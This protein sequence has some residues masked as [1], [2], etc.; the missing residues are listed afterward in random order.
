M[1]KGRCIHSMTGVENS[2]VT[3]GA[4]YTAM[5]WTIPPTPGILAPLLF[6]R[7]L[8]RLESDCATKARS[9]VKR[10][11]PTAHN[12]ARSHPSRHQNV[13]A[14]AMRAKIKAGGH[15]APCTLQAAQQMNIIEMQGR[16]GETGAFGTLGVPF[17]PR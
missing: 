16:G 4:Y 3:E 5:R 1:N 15:A 9:K 13:R 11:K 14:E 6:R 2:K 8:C 7:G 17:P 10:T 12:I